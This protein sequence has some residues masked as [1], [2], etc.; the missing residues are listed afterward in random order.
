[1]HV[2]QG[3]KNNWSVNSKRKKK[4]L[5]CDFFSLV[6]LEDLYGGSAKRQVSGDTLCI[7]S[8]E[9][10]CGS[11]KNRLLNVSVV[12]DDGSDDG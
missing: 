6:R 4:D 10:E 12:C 3:R 1:M 11:E 9:M 8:I 2:S 5:C 7:I